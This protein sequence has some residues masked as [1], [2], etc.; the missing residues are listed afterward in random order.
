MNSRT[1]AANIERRA[2]SRWNSPPPPWPDGTPTSTKL[3]YL[4]KAR[5]LLAIVGNNDTA[6]LIESLVHDYQRDITLALA[7]RRAN[8]NQ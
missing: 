1:I 3:A 7:R 5:P 4:L 2:K 6:S 8:S